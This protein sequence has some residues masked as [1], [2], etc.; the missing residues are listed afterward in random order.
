[1]DRSEKELKVML[2]LLEH[3]VSRD[4]AIVA[5]N[6]IWSEQDLDEIIS[7]PPEKVAEIAQ[8]IKDL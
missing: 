8:D 6:E 7:L 4:D 2:M 1:M 5:V 3:G